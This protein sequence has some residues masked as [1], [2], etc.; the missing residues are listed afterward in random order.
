MNSGPSVASNAAAL[1]AAMGTGPVFVHSDPFRAA[2]LVPRTR[3]RT[4]FLESHVELIKEITAGRTLVIPSF[5]YDFPRTRVFD[6]AHDE[7]QLG[8]LPEHYRT[9][10]AQWRTP[11]PIFSV[12]GAGDDPAIQWGDRSDPF[13]PESVFAWLVRHDGV[14]MYYGDTFQYNTIVH[15]AERSSG[16]PLYRYDKLFPGE[17]VA[18]DGTRT[19]GSLDYHVR[20]MGTGLEYDWKKL[21]DDALNAGV[22]RRLESQPQIL[23]A[24]ARQLCE[25]WLDALE[26][27]PLALLDGASL[28]WVRPALDKLGRRFEID[29]FEP[30]TTSPVTTA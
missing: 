13:G 16:G 24:S 23:V 20:P 18:A 29:D 3:D 14:V 1:A 15:Y 17:V 4:A 12:S 27:D 7:A 26:R 11:I 21:V 30:T 19:M 5:N 9:S 28:E 6:V 8:P 25:H 2:R 10:V 22:C